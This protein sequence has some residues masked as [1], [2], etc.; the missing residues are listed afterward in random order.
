MAQEN[1]GNAQMMNNPFQVRKPAIAGNLLLR[2]PQRE[3]YA[4]LANFALDSNATDREVGIVLP[5]GCGKSGCITIAPFAFKS[6][7]CLVVAPNVKIAQQLY[8]DFDMSNPK[9]FYIKCEVLK[10]GPYPEAA[11]I[12][13]ETT[14]QA[15]LEI[16]RVVVT[17]IQQLQGGQNRWLQEL[18]DNFFDLILFDEGHHNVAESWSILK[19]KFRNARIVNFS[20][21][22]HR[23]DGQLMAGKILYSYPV[24]QAILEGYVKSLQGVMLKPQTLRYIRRGKGGETEVS[25]DEVRRLGEQDAEFRRSI[26][27]SDE[28][29][30]T[31]VDASIR[32]L[33]NLRES[34]MDGRLKII[35]S[36][37]NFEHCRQIVEAYSARGLRAGYV[38]SREASA[39]NRSV[40]KKLENHELDVI[41]QVRKLGEGFDH[42]WLAV[43]AI[44]SVFANL[45]PFIQFVGRIMRV[46]KQNAPD[47]INNQGRVVFHV[48]ANIA[49]QWADFKDFSEADRKFFD[50]LLPLK[51]V[52][53]SPSGERE[54]P[55]SES[56]DNEQIQIR[57]QTEVSL[58]EIPLIDDLEARTAVQTLH[59]KGCTL[60]QIEQMYA[61]LEPVPVSQVRQ[62]QAKRRSLEQRVKNK[63][64]QILGKRELNPGGHEL[65]R[66]RLGRSNYVVIKSAIDRHI[67]SEVG[68]GTRERKKFTRPQL[69]KVE[70]NFYVI[71]ERALREVF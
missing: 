2:K 28:T 33:R 45:S 30:F 3:A 70:K 37:L 64:G 18:S 49:C 54:T 65:D 55:P 16:A 42:P 71:V 61:R 4:E 53:I 13:G 14:N 56:D 48:G 1:E 5:V 31:I 6:E 34:A 41:V 67:N 36:A 59:Q 62:R 50:D 11:E 60:D 25:L 38:H 23:A 22:P 39:A 26:V 63:V 12:R 29:L 52:D 69:D 35:A 15:D 19:N 43:A 9:M 40:L 32:E 68:R 44:F 8:A 27:T 17:N 51:E 21:T 57:S 66:N 58:E 20:A 24:S 7:R 10:G 47:D 46:I